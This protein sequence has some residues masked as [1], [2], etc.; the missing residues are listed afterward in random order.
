[1]RPSEEFEEIRA[2]SAMTSRRERHRS[3]SRAEGAEIESVLG[4]SEIVDNLVSQWIAFL[5]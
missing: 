2:T 1:M 4:S 3:L 5:R